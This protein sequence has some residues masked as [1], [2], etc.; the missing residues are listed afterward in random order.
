MPRPTTEEREARLPTPGEHDPFDAPGIPELIAAV[1][2][3]WPKFDSGKLVW[4]SGVSV[5]AQYEYSYPEVTPMAEISHFPEIHA[6]SS[7]ELEATH[8]PQGC[9]S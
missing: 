5:G 8:S 9:V 7:G 6:P 1:K 2:G 3:I 4:Q